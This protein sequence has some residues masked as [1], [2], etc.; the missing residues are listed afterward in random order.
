MSNGNHVRPGEVISSSLINQILDRIEALEQAAATQPPPQP[1]TG[2]IRI[3]GFDP[4]SAQEVGRVLAILGA[5]LPFPPGADT[6][7]IGSV[8]VPVASLRLAPSNRERLELVVPDLGQL[9]AGGENLFV[10]VRQGSSSAQRL[11]RFQPS[12]GGPATPTITCVR[13]V[14]ATCEDP[15][16]NAM[17][18]VIVIEGSGF[19]VAPAVNTIRFTPLGG[20]PP[21]APYPRAGDPPLTPESAS[22]SEIRVV[23]PV[24]DEIEVTDGARRVRVEVSVPGVVD[25]G[26]FELFVFRTA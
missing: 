26:S 4:P 3:D 10:R 7:A 19:A 16:P 24:M 18:S 9:A 14:G 21:A 13:P 15:P 2:A 8:P 25:A 12:S 6:V 1:G 17:N 20:T 23:V 5:N 11:Y 22:A